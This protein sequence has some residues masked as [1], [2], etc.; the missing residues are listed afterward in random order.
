[1]RLSVACN[2]DPELIEGLKGYP[3]YEVYGKLTSDYFGGGRPSFYLPEVDKKKL[4]EFVALTHKS[5]IEF[6]YLLNAT[7]MGN[8]EFTTEGQRELTKMLDWLSDIGVD[9]VTTASLFFLRTMKKRYPNLKVRISSHR[10][11]DTPRKVRFWSEE[12]A[13]CIVLSEVNI[14]REFEDLKTMR[15]ST[16]VDL[17]L[18]VNNSCRQD[19]AIAGSHAVSLNAASQDGSKD[20]GYPIDY[21][22][23]SCM[24]IRL[25]D[26]V[27]FIRANWIRP[28]DLERYE[29]LG[30]DNFKIVERNT[31]TKAL[32]ERVKA[33]SERYY[34]G[35]LADL[36]LAWNYSED[37][38]QKQDRDFYSYRR[39]LKYFVKPKSV[40]LF[41]FW[42]IKELGEHQ[43]LLY[44]RKAG[45][46]GIYI[47]NRALDGFL[48][49]WPKHGCLSRDCNK[50]RYCNRLADKAV[51]I[52][53]AYRD[54]AL[55]QFQE[56]FEE[57]HSGGLW[58]SHLKTAWNSAK[59]IAARHM[60]R[61]Q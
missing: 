1:M 34:E 40:N 39:M 43:S 10:Y 4:E 46:N 48:D 51:R 44:P 50:C 30:Y 2:F 56:L 60:P 9:S 12:G 31:P 37:K 35:N 52:D 55:D 57:M 54:K 3:V 59:K 29:A 28:E 61:Q 42:K 19:C 58:E 20:K 41:K 15:E 25:Q 7:S 17:S 21:W 16:D 49:H 26:P 27:N 13:D 45:T 8:V 24:Q 32:L 33:Y 23:L 53:P 11:T 22:M 18:I 5:G 6:N 14:Y 36:I 38:Y 47:D